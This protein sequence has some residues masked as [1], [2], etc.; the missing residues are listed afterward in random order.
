[1]KKMLFSLLLISTVMVSCS[2]DDAAPSCA[3]SVSGIAGS[4]KITKKELVANG[5]STDITSGLSSCILSGI[6]RLNA[7]KTA[8]YT[9]AGSSCTDSWSGGSWDVVS[10]KLIIKDD[11]NTELYN[12]TISSWNCSNL[13]ISESGNVGGQIVNNVT[14][15]TKQ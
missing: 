10:N 1:M 8:T 2:K 7:D 9:E 15:F 5:I 11:A 12:A 3:T 6:Y 4:F 13:L 14:T